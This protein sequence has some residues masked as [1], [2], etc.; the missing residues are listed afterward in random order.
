MYERDDTTMIIRLYFRGLTA[1]AISNEIGISRKKVNEELQKM[2]VRL[3]MEVFPDR[4]ISTMFSAFEQELRSGIWFPC[5]RKS[6]DNSKAKAFLIYE[7]NKVVYTHPIYNCS[8]YQLN[9]MAKNLLKMHNSSGIILMEK[10]GIVDYNGKH[11]CVNNPSNRI[12]KFIEFSRERFRVV[13]GIPNKHFS[14]HLAETEYRFK[15]RK[16]HLATKVLELLRDDLPF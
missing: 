5:I 10:L 4:R 6:C 15:N 8:N 13:N 16:E 1:T 2:R 14:M 11:T 9:R 12:E 3:K 7:S